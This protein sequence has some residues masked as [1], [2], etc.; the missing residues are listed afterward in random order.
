M[1]SG[2]PC[3]LEVDSLPIE[4]VQIRLPKNRSNPMGHLLLAFQRLYTHPVLSKKTEVL[5]R[6]G[7]KTKASSGKGC[8]GMSLWELF[9]LAELRLC[10]NI[11]YDD[12]MD[13]ANEHML[14]RGI[15]GLNKRSGRTTSEK[16]YSKS[17]IYD[18]LILVDDATLR[19]INDVVVELGHEVFRHNKKKDQALSLK[20]DSFVVETDTHFPTDYRSLFESSRKCLELIPSLSEELN[21]QGWRQWKDNRKKLKGAYRSF[22]T[23]TSN[24]GANKEEREKL[25]CK[26][27]VEQAD[28]LA[29]KV[30]A[31]IAE[32][33]PLVDDSNF[34]QLIEIEW[35][36]QM[37]IKHKDQLQR[38]VIQGEKI[39]HQEKIFSIF[40][41]FAEWINKGKREVEI[42]NRVSV[43]T[44]QYHLMVDYHIGKHQQDKEMIL[45]IMDR[46]LSKYQAKSWSTDKGFSTKDN[47]AI[48]GLCLPDL[49]LVMPKRGKR[50]KAEEEEEKGKSFVKLKNK[51]SAIE[52]NINELEHRGL[53]RCPDRS[54][55]AFDKYVGLAVIAYN[56]QKIG[57]EI[58]RQVFVAQGKQK[59]KEEKLEKQRQLKRDKEKRRRKLQAA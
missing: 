55:L 38:R 25:A 27:F 22:G 7:L 50:N 53:N 15:L 23:V 54:E 47:K 48:I 58:S 29:K 41:P 42:G 34:G 49:E 14:L 37:L 21:L 11:S 46:I 32:A 33:F 17:T 13:L 40:L 19:Q 24:G 1:R 9:V 3:Q 36:H 6:S 2:F 56:M 31:F 5:L 45:P 18:N 43:T 59:E 4:D 35:F 26:L 52:S 28:T 30:A 8:K 12:V 51:H 16:L 20:T 44:D 57:K 39:P 10:L